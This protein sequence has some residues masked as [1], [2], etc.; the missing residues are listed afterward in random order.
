MKNRISINSE[1]SLIEIIMSILIFAIAGAIMLNCFGAAKFTQMKAND[2]VE[3]IAEMIKSFNT[4]IEAD[5]YLTENFK[6]LKTD[7]KEKIYVN[8]Y[9]KCWNLCEKGNEEN[10]EYFITV[11]TSDVFSG[12][13]QLKEFVITSEK[14]EPYPFISKN[15]K[16]YSLYKIETKK[17][18]SIAGR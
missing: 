18:F 9:D 6:L 16:N 11:K 14:I 2:K 10:N 4:S 13:G 17:F 3:A 15:K 5:E 1:V 7:G 8:Y 12:S